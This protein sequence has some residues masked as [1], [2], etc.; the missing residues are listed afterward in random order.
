MKDVLLTL[1]ALTVAAGSVACGREASSPAAPPAAFA[2]EEATIDDI[3]AAIRRAGR[4]AAPSCRPTSIARAAYNGVCTSLVT[5]DGADIATRH[6]LRARRG[7]ADVSDTDDEGVDDLSG[8]GSVPRQ[9]ARLRPHG[10][11]DLR[12]ER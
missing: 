7:A 8:S 6:R 4:P 10:A 12:P 11:D 3:H 9:A 5:A 2:V 1:V